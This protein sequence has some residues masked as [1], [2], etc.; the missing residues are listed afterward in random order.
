M[1]RWVETFRPN[2]TQLNST[3]IDD[4]KDNPIECHACTQVGVPVFHS[5]T[6]DTAHQP[7]WEVSAGSSLIPIRNRFNRRTVRTRSSVKRR[8]SQSSGRI[9]DPRSKRVQRLNRVIVLARGVAL[10][11]DPLFFFAVAVGGGD[12]PCIYMDGRVAVVAT[13][14]RT[15]MDA[16]HLCHL[17]LQFRLAYLSKE[18]MV[19]GCGKL[20]WDS[21]AIAS[22]YVWSLKG[23]WFDAFVILPIPQVSIVNFINYR[24][25]S[26]I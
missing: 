1:P 15:C 19:V 10:A 22:H 5:T 17:W 18:S 8:S 4:D 9:L 13:V 24:G 2:K 3:D 7:F 11:V 25:S 14:L 23:I 16:V 6:C 21:R 26:V 20:V 12:R